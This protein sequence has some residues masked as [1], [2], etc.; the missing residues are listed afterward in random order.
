MT[1]AHL[2]TVRGRRRRGFELNGNKSIESE[3]TKRQ[4]VGRILKAVRRGVGGVWGT[5]L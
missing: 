1:L 4:W 2:F 3:T 5:G